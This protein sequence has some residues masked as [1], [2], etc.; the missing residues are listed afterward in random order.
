MTD[1]PL[2]LTTMDRDG[3]LAE[4]AAGASR[5]DLLTGAAAA[6]LAGA[7]LVGF[8]ARADAQV[9]RSDREILNYALTLEE[10]QAAFYSEAERIGALRGRARLAAETVGGVER[11]H[12]R[13]FR[14]LLGRRAIRKPSFDFRGTT[15]DED[16]FLRTAVALEDLSV[17]AYKA[18]APRLRS[19]EVLMAAIGIHTVEARHAAWM[20]YLFGVQPATRAFDDASDQQAVLRQVARTEFITSAP[21]TEQRRRNPRFTG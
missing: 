17:E 8:P 14:D 12:V 19:P 2:D 3:A 11:A 20:R 6:G 4:T 7:A 21:R 9:P 1:Q 18:Q 5:R 13:A 16:A 10:L 15:E